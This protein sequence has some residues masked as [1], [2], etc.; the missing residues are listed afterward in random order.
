MARTDIIL[1]NR[2]L[3][4]LNPLAAGSENCDRNQH[5]GPAYRK[6]TLLHYVLEGHGTFIAR[7]GTYLV[8]PGQAFLILP[9]EETTYFADHNDPWHYQWLGFDGELAKDFSQLPPVFTMPETLMHKIFLCG[10]GSPLQEYRMASAMMLMYCDL[11]SQRSPRNDHVRRV[12]NYIQ[13]SYN[14]PLT[15]EKIAGRLNLDRR[16][17]SSLF[18]RKT[19][20]TIQ[21]YIIH[22]RLQ[23]A[24]HYL[25]QGMSVQETAHRCGYED[26][27]NFSKMFKKSYG[28]SPATWRNRRIEN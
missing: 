2:H 26:V 21:E 19:G 20:Y 6:Y 14:L 7:G 28:Q 22:I 1:T 24:T 17:L 10:D 15:V 27:S 3:K 18:K 9:D 11:F 25:D 8:G 23:E 13:T 5:F 12:Q 16:Y 4:D